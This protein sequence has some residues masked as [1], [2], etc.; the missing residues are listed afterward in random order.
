MRSKSLA[1]SLLLA[2]AGVASAQPGATPSSPPAP[3]PY[4]PPP[5]GYPPPP[6]NQPQ[7]Q[8]YAQPQPQPY[9]VPVQLTPDENE[10]LMRGEISDGAHVGG[11][12]ASLFIGFGVG[13]AIQGRWGDTGWIFTLGESASFVAL[14]Y[15][16]T[17]MFN[18][19]F[20]TVESTCDNNDGEGLF[21]AGLLGYTVFRTWGVVDA[22]AGPP[23]HNRRVRELRMRLG[24]PQPLY[25]RMLPYVNKT[26]DGGG[27]A[28][29]SLSF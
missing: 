12:I 6:V 19:C 8:P 16:M 25:T 3:D 5:S 11:G 9:L 26:R 13:Q 4:P 17:Q 2:F 10:L 29:L 28:G 27:V 1:L 14:V 15:G 7:P 23:K 22:F 20:A 24:M 21:I 18:D